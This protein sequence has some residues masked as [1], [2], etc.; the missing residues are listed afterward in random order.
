[1]FENSHDKNP[2]LASDR[3]ESTQQENTQDDHH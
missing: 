3:K 1:M 2:H